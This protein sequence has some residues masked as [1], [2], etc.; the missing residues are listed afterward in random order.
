MEIIYRAFDGKEFKEN[1][2]S[3]CGI[4]YKDSYDLNKASKIKFF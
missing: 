2:K 3:L 1:Q 4:F